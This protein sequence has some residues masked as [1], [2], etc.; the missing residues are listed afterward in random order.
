MIICHKIKLDLA[1]S[2]S[3]PRICAA[4]NDKYS[5][6]L[7]LH[8]YANGIPFTPP[9]DCRF[10]IRY[11]KEDGTF[12][13]YDTLPD[14][15]AAWSMEG[16]V[17]TAAL[18]PQVCTAPGKVSLTVTFFSGAAELSSFA[19]LVDVIPAEKGI[20]PSQDYVNITGFLPQTDQVVVG[21]YLA[22]AG[23][24][25]DGRVSA[26]NSITAPKSAYEYAREGG[27]SGTLTEFTAKMAMELDA[28][29]TRSGAMA[30]ARAAGDAIAANA[31][32]ID[33]AGTAIAEN[34]GL[35]Q[36]AQ[37][38]IAEN[39]RQIAVERSRVD[40]FTALAEGSTTGD[41]ELQDIRVGY[42]GLNYST[43]GNAVRE[44]IGQLAG[45]IYDRIPTPNLFVNRTAANLT[46]DQTS[47]VFKGYSSIVGAVIP[48]DSANGSTVTVRK[49]Q[50][51]NVF[52]LATSADYPAHNAA[53]TAFRFN[54]TAT[55]LSI[56]LSEDDKYLY[57]AYYSLDTDSLEQ[58]V[59]E[60]GLRIFYGTEYTEGALITDLLH[61]DITQ[62]LDNL[63]AKMRQDMAEATQIVSA[64][65]NLAEGCEEGGFSFGTYE[66]TPVFK[67][68]NSF[69]G[70]IVPVDPT[71]GATV[72]I[73]A[74]GNTLFRIALS[75][76]KPAHNAAYRQLI[77]NDALSSY[78]LQLSESDRYVYLIYGS[79]A[80]MEDP[81]TVRDSIRVYYGDTWEAETLSAGE[82]LRR[83]DAAAH[84]KCRDLFAAAAA[85][86]I[87]T[88]IDDDTLSTADVL[89]FRD[90]C[91]GN[92]IRGTLA[93]MTMHLEDDQTLSDTLL[94]MEREGFQTVIHCYNQIQSYRYPTEGYEDEA[95]LALC[96]EDLV[97]GLQDLHRAGFTDY[98]FWPTP[99][100]SVPQEFQSLARKWGLE[101]ALT[102]GKKSYETTQAVY[103][104]YALRRAALGPEDGEYTT[105]D[106]LTALA[107]S[108][109]AENGWLIINTHFA[110]WGEDISRFDQF[111][112]YCKSIGFT[113]M[114]LGEA[115]RIR[116][117][118][119]T[120]YETF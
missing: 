40:G 96:E 31:A 51:N 82:L 28:T 88:I 2:R 113:F 8:I 102:T 57:V 86:P 90:A 36:A 92:S 56:P 104:R 89:R 24:S 35:I 34:A 84:S 1:D 110:D 17:V 68:Y 98:R 64:S 54:S 39:T 15:T 30:D 109:Q 99:F 78:T 69:Y 11:V 53:C 16:N 76:E 106:D 46:I 9:E 32:R 7:E 73:S 61:A 80:T 107:D 13:S 3:T 74:E 41:A 59:V 87:C 97:H 18:A 12:G 118:I 119:Y 5:R 63:D 120:L 50:V 94:R 75:A 108:A 37:D 38:A 62:E 115:W 23:V 66:D 4:Q 25:E 95:H 42:E 67:G 83:M 21:Q 22:V 60:D 55:E 43:A 116:K 112:S 117:P 47:S 10:L 93:C 48:V 71:V 105:M 65:E 85:M 20:S 103:G 49:A 58:S 26:L 29:L 45:A 52:T 33:D 114:T 81:D 27:Y 70:I 79:V 77:S 19:I 111:V 101:C 14:G 44:Q 100:G 6:N 72:T 91:M